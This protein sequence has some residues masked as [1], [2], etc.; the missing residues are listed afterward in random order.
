MGAIGTQHHK[1]HFLTLCRERVCQRHHHPWHAAAG[2]AIQEQRQMYSVRAH[3][4]GVTWSG[5][6]LWHVACER[7]DGTR[8]PVEESL[9]GWGTYRPSLLRNCP[10]CRIAARNL[11]GD[12]IEPIQEA[13]SKGWQKAGMAS[14]ADAARQSSRK[15]G[16][17]MW[18]SIGPSGSN[19]QGELTPDVVSPRQPHRVAIHGSIGIPAFARKDQK[20]RRP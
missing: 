7:R 4:L 13:E 11:K 8:L 2:E 12:R 15:T 17:W 16:I 14:S 3:A 18:D 1:I 9:Q 10:A 6:R 5:D 20:G 19:G